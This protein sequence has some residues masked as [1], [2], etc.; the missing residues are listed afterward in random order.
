MSLM[1][2]SVM[3]FAFVSS[4]AAVVGAQAPVTPAGTETGAA[5]DV[6]SQADGV[7]VCG[8]SFMKRILERRRAD[9]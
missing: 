5:E 9:V 6:P 7:G 8:V 1:I 4:L 3:A 2:R